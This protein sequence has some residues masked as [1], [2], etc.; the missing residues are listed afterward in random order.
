MAPIEVT[1]STTKRASLAK[2]IFPISL[3][4]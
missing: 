3:S 4:G 2:Q 1:Q